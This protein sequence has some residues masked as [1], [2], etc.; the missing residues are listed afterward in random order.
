MPIKRLNNSLKDANL[1]LSTKTP[2]VHRNPKYESINPLST[3]QREDAFHASMKHK[4]GVLMM[5]NQASRN[6][7]LFSPVEDKSPVT[8]HSDSLAD[9]FMKR[10]DEFKRKTTDSDRK[11]FPKNKYN[12]PDFATLSFNSKRAEHNRDLKESVSIKSDSLAA[13][14]IKYSKSNQKHIHNE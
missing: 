6:Y 12:K 13:V 7:S 2:I 11:S 5:K 3:K 14:V 1:E 8:K 4:K 10:S 9:K